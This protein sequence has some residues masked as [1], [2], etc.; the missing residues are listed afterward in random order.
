MFPIKDDAGSFFD[1]R[2]F[3]FGYAFDSIEP[4]RLYGRN[5]IVRYCTE[6]MVFRKYSSR[7]KAAFPSFHVGL[8]A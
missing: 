5:D 8:I 3:G 6:L 7:K 4:R 1:D 2:R